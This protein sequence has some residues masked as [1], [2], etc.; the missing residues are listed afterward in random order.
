M[1][2]E[3][4]H[5]LFR[6][7]LLMITSSMVGTAFT[8]APPLPPSSPSPS[9]SPQ[10]HI[11]LIVA[12]DLGW[13]DVSWHNSQVVTPHMEALARSGVLL[14]QSYVQPICTPTRSALLTGRYPFTLGRQNGVLWPMEPTGLDLNATLLPQ[15]LKD[16]GYSTHV[17]GKWHLGYCSWAY[18]PTERGFDTFFGYYTGA[19]HYY[20]HVRP[21]VRHRSNDFWTSAAADESVKIGYDFRNNT[22]PDLD[23]SGTYSTYLF[24]SYI[25][26]LLESRDPQDPMFLYLPFQSVHS[27]NEVPDNYTKPY[28]HIHH[29]DRRIKLGMVTAMDEAVGRVV[30]ALKATRHYNNSII[31]FTTDNGGPT[32]TSGNNWPLRGNKSTLWEGGTRGAAFVHSPLL[33]N[34]GTVSHQLVHVTDWYKTLVGV[35]GGVVPEDTDGVDQWAAI[36]GSSPSPRTNMIYNIDNTTHFVA[37]LRIG[38]YKLLVGNPGPGEWT[39]PPEFTSTTHNP[40]TASTYN[41][42]NASTHNPHMACT[43]SPHTASTHKPHTASTHKPHTASTPKPYTASTHNP[44][45]ASTYNS[46]TASTHNPHTVSTHNPHTT[47]HISSHQGLSTDRPPVVSSTSLPQVI[48][49]GSSRSD[50]RPYNVRQPE[51]S[52][53]GESSGSVGS[54]D[55][56][57][58]P[59]LPDES[60]PHSS[61]HGREA[62]SI[63]FLYK[64]AVTENIDLPKSFLHVRKSNSGGPYVVEVDMTKPD[65]GYKESTHRDEETVSEKENISS[66]ISNYTD[67][68]EKTN[69]TSEA[70]GSGQSEGERRQMTTQQLLHLLNTDMQQIRLYNITEDPEERVNLAATQEAV[71]RQMLQVILHQMSRY[72]P[73]DIKPND[74][75]ANPIFWGNIWS[76][77]WCQPQSASP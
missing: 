74:P 27:P 29:R 15:S 28:N 37:G 69:G 56:D 70:Y 12:D 59:P 33:P 52:Q 43:H 4:I 25:E 41:S 16:A 75:S 63:M 32:V 5:P 34:P 76:P 18:T 40:R 60:L 65:S 45:T 38:D 50:T 6:F 49:S 19:E 31:V 53:S 66:K 58:I 9:A 30:K 17:V 44:H 3:K 73:A 8:T 61:G 11:I 26:E 22:Q 24:A 35:A 13:N 36:T 54:K 71:V 7:L 77:G 68:D 64:T 55:T 14:E 51:Y 46:Q 72:V 42:Q 47:K 48:Q 62:N 67:E 21:P 57:I 20:S 23:A 39:P 1:T 10:P 2:G